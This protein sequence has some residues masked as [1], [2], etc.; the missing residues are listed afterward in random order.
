M[1]KLYFATLP[2]SARKLIFDHDVQRQAKGRQTIYFFKKSTKF[3]TSRF[4]EKYP[5]AKHHEMPVLGCVLYRSRRPI[6]FGT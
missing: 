1:N 5:A 2:E 4:L 6:T 3:S